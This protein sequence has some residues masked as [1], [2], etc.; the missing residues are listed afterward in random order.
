MTPKLTKEIIMVNTNSL[1]TGIEPGTSALQFSML[2]ERRQLN[3][4]ISFTE[5]NNILTKKKQNL[6]T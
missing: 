5:T 2:T 1:E 3:I 6:N 4:Y